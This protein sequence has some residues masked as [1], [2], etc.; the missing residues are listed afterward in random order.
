MNVSSNVSLPCVSLLYISFHYI[1]YPYAVSYSETYA[2][3]AVES[4]DGVKEIESRIYVPLPLD[5]SSCTEE[6]IANVVDYAGS[7]P[8]AQGE[9]CSGSLD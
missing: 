9:T 7:A 5:V 6:K 4:Q 2:R 8:D 1:L 3:R